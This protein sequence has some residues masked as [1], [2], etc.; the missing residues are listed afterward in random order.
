MK[1]TDTITPKQIKFLRVLLK[2]NGLDNQPDIIADLAKQFSN[3]R[4]EHTSVL[5]QVEFRGLVAK[6]SQSNSTGDEILRRLQW[7]LRYAFADSKYDNYCVGGNKKKPN[8]LE[9]DSFCLKQ[10][11]KR[12]N[13]MSEDEMEKYISIVKHW[14]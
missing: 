1:N 14:K 10:W 7:K 5:R 2:Q 9:I 6:L 3:D 4:T 8:M 12:V 11:K 13:E